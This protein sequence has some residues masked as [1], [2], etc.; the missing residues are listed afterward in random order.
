M[1]NRLD[2]WVADVLCRVV[3]VS[4][5]TLICVANMEFKIQYKVFHGPIYIV[6]L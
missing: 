6:E 3:Q 5:T 2:H 1:I 4:L